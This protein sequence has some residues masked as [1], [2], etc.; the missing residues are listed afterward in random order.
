MLGFVLNRENKP[1]ES[2][3]IYT[4]AAQLM[5]PK[6]DDLKVV[7]LDY[8]LLNDNPDT[9]RWMPQAVVYLTAGG[10]R[11]RGNVLSGCS[12]LSSNDMRVHFGLGD[13]ARAGA[14]EIRWP[15]GKGEAFRSPAMDRTFSITEGRGITRKLCAPSGKGSK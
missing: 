9:V 3:E 13:A 5:R 2:L 11:Q 4:Q 1:A 6:S 7:A 12:H 15:N 14:I 8:A 10:I